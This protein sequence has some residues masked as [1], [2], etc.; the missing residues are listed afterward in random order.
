M[1]AADLANGSTVAPPHPPWV[2]LLAV[3]P[4]VAYLSIY[5]SDPLSRLPVREITRP[6]DNKS[7]P[8]LETGSFG[9]FST[10]ERSMRSSVRAGGVRYVFFASS[11]RRQPRALAGLYE[12]G[13]WAYGTLAG[14]PADICLAASRIHFLET[15]IPL[16]RLP[17]PAR[18]VVTTRFRT[19]KRLDASCTAQLARIVLARPDATLS[20]LA[21][22]DRLE[23]FNAKHSGF[24]C[25]RR[26]EAFGWPQAAALI[27]SEPAPLVGRAP[28]N[29]SVSGRWCCVSCG[30]ALENRSRLKVCPGCS[31]QDTLEPAD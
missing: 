20:Y 25:W 10:C 26:V 27:R 4:A 8:N 31:E 23:R 6:R 21:E 30:Y 29:S 24:R 13:W 11:H 16:E 1:F 9:L 7:D 12:I 17:Q 2:P 15:P 14:K 19:I 18:E 22:I 5:Y 3:E 28:R